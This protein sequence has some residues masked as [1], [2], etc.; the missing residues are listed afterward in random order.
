MKQIRT[1]YLHTELILWCVHQSENF[2]QDQ[3]VYSFFII[4]ILYLI[5]AEEPLPPAKGYV[6]AY[7][8]RSGPDNLE[9]SA[10]K[11]E[12]EAFHFKRATFVV[13][14]VGEVIENGCSE[15]DE[16]ETILIP[17]NWQKY[18][19]TGKKEEGYLGYGYV[20]FAFMVSDRC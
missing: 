3:V 11:I 8:R 18:V 15:S 19:N 6:S 2:Q 1:L 12:Y 9:H 5:C 10:P 14:P 4:V 16:S 17:K 13:T 7:R 20:K